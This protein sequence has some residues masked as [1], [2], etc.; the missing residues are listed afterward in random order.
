MEPSDET[1]DRGRGRNNGQ[2]GR[3]VAIYVRVS[4]ARQ[5]REGVSLDAQEATCRTLAGIHWP[6]ADSAL[7]RDVASGRREARPAYAR[8]R[9]AV[10]LRRVRAVVSYSHDRLSRSAAEFNAFC[11]A[12]QGAGVDLLLHRTGI[13]SWTPIGSFTLQLLGILAEFES[14]QVGERT[15]HAIAQAE[16]I[17]RKGP[18][19]RPFGWSVD[20]AGI[21]HRNEREQA[22]VDLAASLHDRG[23]SWAEVAAEVSR[24]GVPTVTGRPWSVDAIRRVV[25]TC[26]ARR[27]REA[28]RVVHGDGGLPS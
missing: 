26:Q 28:T 25:S 20:D 24:V 13:A 7:Y 19:L 1:G 17:G 18:G 12:C 21:L 15:R 27:A 10:R 2:D 16:A 6:G 23:L 4:T 8:L 22:V 11:R 9:E 14:A 5:E 3:A